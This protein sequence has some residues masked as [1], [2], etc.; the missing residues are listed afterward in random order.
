MASIYGNLTKE[1]ETLHSMVLSLQSQHNQ[2]KAKQA[3]LT[4]SPSPFLLSARPFPPPPPPPP[5]TPA[6]T[7][8]ST[9]AGAQ[10]NPKSN[11]VS[12]TQTTVLNAAINQG[13]QFSEGGKNKYRGATPFPHILK[14]PGREEGGHIWGCEEMV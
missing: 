12:E 6:R 3:R 9:L 11:R 7:L 2:D 14:T 5:P 1:E 13:Q 8:A 4:A 10:C